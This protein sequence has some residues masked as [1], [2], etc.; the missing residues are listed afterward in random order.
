MQKIPT[1]LDLVE[2][3]SFYQKSRIIKKVKTDRE[4]MYL[5]DGRS[6]KLKVACSSIEQNSKERC[7]Y[8]NEAL[9]KAKVG[10]IG[11]WAFV[12]N[13]FAGTDV[14]VSLVSKE[15]VAFSTVSDID[16][17]MQAVDF[18]QACLTYSPVRKSLPFHK[19]VQLFYIPDALLFRLTKVWINNDIGIVE[20][21]YRK[22][23]VIKGSFEFRLKRTADVLTRLYSR[24]HCYNLVITPTETYIMPSHGGNVILGGRVFLGIIST[25]DERFFRYMQTD[26]KNRDDS[27]SIPDLSSYQYSINEL[28]S[29]IFTE[30]I[31]TSLDISN[32][33][34]QVK[35]INVNIEQVLIF[36]CSMEFVG[37]NVSD[38]LKV[39]LKRHVPVF[40]TDKRGNF[41]FS[42][43]TCASHVKGKDVL[44]IVK[45]FDKNILILL[46]KFIRRYKL[47][48]LIIAKVVLPQ[49]KFEVEIIH[50]EAM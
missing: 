36:E 45:R 33:L 25:E 17:W 26:P 22:A 39:Q 9:L 27:F 11:D 4:V 1:I 12:G 32:L 20:D 28:K 7:P 6:E 49:L 44:V 5:M 42:D 46:K 19:H 13:K 8:C 41:Y 10:E 15:H 38:V 48:N 30:N 34:E 31:D 18:T 35:D 47:R 24:G 16:I 29:L 37:E 2:S 43:I 21:D 3:V 14:E 23:L 50:S 40:V